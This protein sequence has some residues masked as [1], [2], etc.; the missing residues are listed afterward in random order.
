MRQSNEQMANCVPRLSVY[1]AYNGDLVG[2]VTE[3][4]SVIPSQGAG[5]NNS[6]KERCAAN[7][8]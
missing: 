6:N 4:C 1:G 3:R 8:Y 5:D 2:N 7:S